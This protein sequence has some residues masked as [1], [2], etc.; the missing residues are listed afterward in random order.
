MGSL[1]LPDLEFTMIKGHLTELTNKHSYNNIKR[2]I[3]YIMQ[4]W[5]CS[6]VLILLQCHH[7]PLLRAN[8][9]SKI[10]ILFN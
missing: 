5:S 4:L 3:K 10:C 8:G 2:Y 1:S 9:P 6:A 7:E